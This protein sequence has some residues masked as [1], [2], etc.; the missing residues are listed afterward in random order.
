MLRKQDEIPRLDPQFWQQP[1]PLAPFRN[2][3]HV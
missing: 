1:I 3:N 2:I